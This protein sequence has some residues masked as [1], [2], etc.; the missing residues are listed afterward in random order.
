MELSKTAYYK[1]IYNRNR[2]SKVGEGLFIMKME[3][4]GLISVFSAASSSS[5][6]VIINMHLFLVKMQVNVESK[7]KIKSHTAKYLISLQLLINKLKNQ[8]LKC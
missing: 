5:K 6:I 7:I 8:G 2:V 4:R 1:I 3:H